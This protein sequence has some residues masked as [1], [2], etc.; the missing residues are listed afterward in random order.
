VAK[1]TPLPEDPE[2]KAETVPLLMEKRSQRNKAVALTIGAIIGVVL[3]FGVVAKV[4]LVVNKDYNDGIAARVAE[5]VA[6][7]ESQIVVNEE[8][9]IIRIQTGATIMTTVWYSKDMNEPIVKHAL[10][11]E[12]VCKSSSTANQQAMAQIKKAASAIFITCQNIQEL[13]R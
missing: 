2:T 6:E 12:A 4:T 9:D 8:E 13:D 1:S 5:K 10:V 3:C 7:Q 11:A